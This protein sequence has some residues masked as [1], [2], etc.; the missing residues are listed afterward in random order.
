M[1]QVQEK[2]QRVFRMLEVPQAGCGL[3]DE[4]LGSMFNVNVLVGPRRINDYSML[5]ALCFM[6]PKGWWLEKFVLWI[7]NRFFFPAQIWQNLDL[8]D[9]FWNS[10]SAALFSNL[11]V[12]GSKCSRVVFYSQWAAVM[13]NRTWRRGESKDIFHGFLGKCVCNLHVILLSP[14]KNGRTCCQSWVERPGTQNFSEGGEL[15]GDGQGKKE[16][17]HNNTHKYR[18]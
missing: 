10:F 9:D 6:I 15:L 8:R 18:L 3:W 1:K 13:R 2:L 7:I 5:N 11:T 16:Q 4:N 14:A 17:C 12:D